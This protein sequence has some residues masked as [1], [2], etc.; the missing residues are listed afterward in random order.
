MPYYYVNTGKDKDG[1][2]EVHVEGCSWLPSVL[3]RDYLGNY[4]NCRPAVTEAISRG[5]NANGCFHCSKPCH[6]G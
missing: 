6:T 4:S 2:N 5:Y 3:N 1:H